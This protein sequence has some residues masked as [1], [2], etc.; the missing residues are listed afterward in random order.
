MNADILPEDLRRWYDV[1]FNGVRDAQ[2][3][4]EQTQLLINELRHFPDQKAFVDGLR[5]SLLIQNKFPQ[6]EK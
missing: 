2:V 5:V 4:A 1:A 6:N 3:E